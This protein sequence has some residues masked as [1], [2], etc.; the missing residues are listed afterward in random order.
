M[1]GRGHREP[2]LGT[3]FAA[4]IAGRALVDAGI[5]ASHSLNGQDGAKQ[6]D[7]W[8]TQHGQGSGSIVG[9]P[10]ALEERGKMKRFV[11]IRLL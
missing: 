10:A 1:D 4:H 8:A 5:L 2:E 7:T 3:S 9:E 6:S 11:W